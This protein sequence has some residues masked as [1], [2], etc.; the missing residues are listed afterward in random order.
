MAVGTAGLLNHK[1]GEEYTCDSNNAVHIKFVKNEDDVVNED[2]TF[3]PDMSHQVFGDSETIFGYKDLQVQLY[4][5]AGSLL[6]YLGMKYQSKVPASMH[7]PPDP[8]LPAIAEKLPQG[9]CTNLDVFMSKLGDEKE[10][11]P[12]GE[13]IHEYSRNDLDY[14]IYQG[15]INTPGLNEYH[16]RLQTFILWFIDAASFIDADDEKWNFF[17]LFERRKVNSNYEYSIVGYMTVYQYFAYPNKIRP[18][19]SQMLVLPPFQRKGHGVELLSSVYRHYISNIDAVDITVEDPSQD[20]VALRDYLDCKRCAK[21]DAF[22]EEKLKEGFNKDMETSGV[23]K[24]KITRKQVRR[25]Y[26]ILRL[27]ATSVLDEESYKGFRLDVKRR[28][29]IP[30]QKQA[31][32]MKKLEKVLSGEEYQAAMVGNTNAER[33]QRLDDAYKELEE[34]YQRVI[35]RLAKS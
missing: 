1:K 9:Y 33:V 23:E 27:Q 5:H 29:N 10:F 20:F 21:M 34:E 35:A 4:Y 8:V 15:N 22:R 32:D 7:I 31:R 6:T 24:L 3:H 14:E 16:Q 18:R 12:F 19:I 26:E 11:K 2:N 30:Y 28:L 17:F 13:K 25:V